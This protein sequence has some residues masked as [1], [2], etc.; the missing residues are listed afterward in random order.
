MEPM[1]IA[2]LGAGLLAAVEKLLEKGVIDPALE[3]GTAPLREWLTRGYDEQKDAQELDQLV[4]AA[5]EA[6]KEQFPDGDTRRY[7]AELRL[8]SLDKDQSAALAAA[9]VEFTRFEPSLLPEALLQRLELKEEQRDLLARFLSL[10][11]K[12]L[13]R[14]ERYAA[15]IAYAD[16]MDNRQALTGLAQQVIDLQRQA[17]RMASLQELMARARRLTGDDARVLGEYLA[18]ARQKWGHIQ[19]PLIRR[20]SGEVVQTGLKQVYVP[21][22]LRAITRKQD[23]SSSLPPGE[24]L[25]RYP[26]FALLGSPGSGKTTLLYRIALAFAENRAAEDL[27]WKGPPLLPLF[28]RLRNFG[29]F[30][31]EHKEEYPAPCP[32]ALLAHFENE[33]RSG[34]RQFLTPDFFDRR[35]KEGGCIVLLDGLDEVS[36]NRVE[37]AQHVATFINNYK[38]DKK[39]KQ[40]KEDKQEPDNRFGISSRPQGYATA[41]WQLRP[42]NLAEAEVRPLEKDGIQA[43]IHNLFV[44]IEADPRQRAKDTDDLGRSI[45]ARA[46]LTDIASTPLF[47]AALVQV[48]KHH[49]ARLPERRVDVLDEIVHLLLGFWR[50]QQQVANPEQLAI[51]DLGGRP[52]RLEEAVSAKRKRL[53]FL[54]YQ[55][56]MQRKAELPAPEAVELL[57]VY[58]KERERIKDEEECRLAAEEFLVHSHEYSGLL[59]EQ[60]P[61][62]YAFLHK[63]FMEYLAATWLVSRNEVIA[64]ALQYTGHPE[65]DW[66]EPVILLAG[67]H[68]EFV[69][70]FRSELINKLLDRAGEAAAPQTRAAYLLMA[71]K[72]ATDMAG[73]LPGPEHERAQDSLLGALTA[74]ETALP[75]RDRARVGVVLARL[76]DPRPEVLTL[77]SMPFCLVLAGPFEMG[78]ERKKPVDLPA[79]WVGQYPVTAAQFNLFVEVGGYHEARYWQDAARAGWWR[80]GHFK[81]R[82]DNE[83]RDRPVQFGEPFELPNHPVVGVSWYEAAAFCRWLDELAH[84]RGWLPQEWQVRLPEESQWE[85]AARGGQ[86]IPD[87]PIIRA[88]HALPPAA[89]EIRLQ[90]NPDPRRAYPWEGGFNPDNANIDETG[91]KATSAVGGFPGGRSPY[92]ALEMGGGV[93]EWQGNWYDQNQNSKGLRGGSWN[94]V[95]NVARCAYRDR[96]GPGNRYYDVGFRCLLSRWS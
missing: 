62:Q 56:Q 57:A 41:Q 74:R 77:E 60:E 6:L 59:V 84:A 48:Y 35:L 42:A 18:W 71:G 86:Q 68:T 65:A 90:N 38:K 13:G 36:E 69:E 23:N 30:L 85:K 40:D 82:A 14:S 95:Q 17:A 4:N 33:Y 9:A 91:I 83:A 75:A 10:L 3:R 76:G 24:L 29:A 45:L 34:E 21:L 89:P 58:L 37:V 1:L 50:V 43:L 53:S 92:G 81:G 64:A 22:K 26:R 93:W 61:G 87:A 44:L 80:N 96:D 32:G 54:A 11:R 16:A 94:I 12:G 78:D 15:A 5:L 47:C 8:G 49:G 2:G 28:T 46:E 7:F 88:L 51:K 25:N 31:A 73:Y 67:A 27:G 63:A 20:R 66:W 70:V 52:R 55:M 39:D 72:L 19:L 79:F